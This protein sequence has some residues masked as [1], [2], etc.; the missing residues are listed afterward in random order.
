MGCCPKQLPPLRRQAATAARAVSRATAQALA[1][2][3]VKVAT[4]VEQARLDICY[5]CPEASPYAK[6][7]Q[8]FRCA[9]CGCWLNG[10]FFAK[11]RLA[12]ESCPLGKWGAQA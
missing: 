9:Q 2:G 7:P 3:P 1:G 4:A 5:L 6:K 11:A 12:T 10:K 8:F